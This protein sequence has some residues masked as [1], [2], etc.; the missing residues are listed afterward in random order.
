M[1]LFFKITNIVIGV[2]AL[3]MLGELLQK[4]EKQENV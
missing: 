1:N 3:V 4:E 2:C